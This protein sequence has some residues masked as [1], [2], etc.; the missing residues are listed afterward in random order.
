MTETTRVVCAP[1]R[2][3]APH[4]QAGM[5]AKICCLSVFETT[6]NQLSLGGVTTPLLKLGFPSKQLL[7]GA[8]RFNVFSTKPLSSE[9]VSPPQRN[10]II[11]WL[12]AAR[13]VVVSLQ[14]R[15]SSLFSRTKKCQTLVTDEVS[16]CIRK[17]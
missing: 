13:T 7:K 12:L 3:P 10:I 17:D 8:I 9:Q 1:S 5:T 2:F 14:S 6:S 15:L 16:A 11:V 4:V